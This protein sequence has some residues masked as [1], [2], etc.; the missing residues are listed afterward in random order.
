MRAPLLSPLA[1][2]AS[3]VTL[4]G[5]PDPEPTHMNPP[6]LWL[7]LMGSETRVQLQPVEPLP[8]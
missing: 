2:A 4:A 5:C 7:A 1:L 3:L 6:R 8:Y